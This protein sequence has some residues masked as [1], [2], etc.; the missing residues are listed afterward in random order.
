MRG[1]DDLAARV[2]ACLAGV[3]G[4]SELMMFGGRRLPP[5]ADSW[6]PSSTGG[7][8]RPSTLRL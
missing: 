7:V 4:M 1:E 6:R 3:E 2:R 8:I 5:T